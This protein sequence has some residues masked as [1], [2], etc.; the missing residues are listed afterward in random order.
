[1]ASKD[2]KLR[3]DQHFRPATQFDPMGN[4]APVQPSKPSTHAVLPIPVERGQAAFKLRVLRC[5]QRK[6]V[7]V[8][9]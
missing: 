5:R 6:L 2:I 4:A 8:G 9:P 7:R 1:M 3:S